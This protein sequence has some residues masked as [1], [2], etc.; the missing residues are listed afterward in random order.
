MNQRDKVICENLISLNF[1]FDLMSIKQM[2]SE[3]K[4]KLQNL[5]TEYKQAT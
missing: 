5:I 4:Q 2:N 1:I 3:S